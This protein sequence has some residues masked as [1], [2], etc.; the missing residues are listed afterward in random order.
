MPTAPL[1]TVSEQFAFALSAPLP[2][3]MA[4]LAVAVVIW[5]LIRWLY[6][7]RYDGVI[8]KLGTVRIRTGVTGN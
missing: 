3:A 4:V 6:Q 1:P 2:F 7:W 5:G 8:E